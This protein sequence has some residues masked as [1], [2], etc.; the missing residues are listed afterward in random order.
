MKTW[1]HLDYGNIIYD[2]VDNKTFHQK[3]KL[4]QYN[5]CLVFTGAIRGTSKAKSY[6]ELGLESPQHRR[7]YRKLL[8]S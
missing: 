4:M 6:E 7:W 5:A 2:Q 1:L 3:L 8:F